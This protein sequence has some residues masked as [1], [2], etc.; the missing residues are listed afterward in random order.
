MREINNEEA[1]IAICQTLIED[2]MKTC[3]ALLKHEVAFVL[4]QLEHPTSV[5]ALLASMRD[6]GEHPMVRHEA[7]EALGA[8]GDPSVMGELREMLSHPVDILRESCV[9]ALHMYDREAFLA[10]GVCV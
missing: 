9:V 5:P 7:A 3:G 1:M 10:A 6:E 2:N 4:G 8:L